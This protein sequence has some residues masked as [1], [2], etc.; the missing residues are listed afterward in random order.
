[1][2]SPTVRIEFLACSNSFVKRRPLSCIP[3]KYCS[4]TE[5]PQRRAQ[6]QP[7]PAW[8][9]DSIE[10]VSGA[11][12]V[13]SVVSI[14][15]DD[16]SSHVLSVSSSGDYGY[17]DDVGYVCTLHGSI[18]QER[19]RVLFGGYWNAARGESGTHSKA[20]CGVLSFDLRHAH[21]ADTSVIAG[22]HNG[23]ES[24]HISTSDAQTCQERR[25]SPANARRKIFNFATFDLFSPESLPP[26]SWSPNTGNLLQII[27]NFAAVQA[28]SLSD[29]CSDSQPSSSCLRR[30]CFAP[31]FSPRE[32][33]SGSNM[34]EASV[35]F[36]L[37]VESM[38]NL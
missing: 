7:M 1:M 10:V 33:S 37:M 8:A 4:M 5:V 21:E 3:N 25:G 12:E 26:V 14:S 22:E 6:Q 29:S 31:G 38:T 13:P 11:F 34:S 20:S 23:N 19:K 24:G 28:I 18:Q 16:E 32:L 30:K 15:N 27:A 9:I 2:Y 36:H 35:S 17:E